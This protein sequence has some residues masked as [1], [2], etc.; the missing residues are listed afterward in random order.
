MTVDGPA[1]SYGKRARGYDNPGF[2]A[3]A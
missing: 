1:L 2:I 3:S